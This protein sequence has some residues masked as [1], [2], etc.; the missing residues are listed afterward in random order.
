MLVYKQRRAHLTGCA[1]FGTVLVQDV[2]VCVSCGTQGVLLTRHRGS[3]TWQFTQRREHP[4]ENTHTEKHA[5]EW[6]G[7]L[8]DGFTT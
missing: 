8:Y 4:H 2:C 7:R 5:A 3:G 1:G 6:K